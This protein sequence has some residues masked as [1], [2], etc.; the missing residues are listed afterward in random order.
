MSDKWYNPKEILGLETFHQICELFLTTTYSV[1]KS[2]GLS[3]PK[4]KDL[5][6]SVNDDD[7]TVGTPDKFYYVAIELEKSEDEEIYKTRISVMTQLHYNNKY[8]LAGWQS[9]DNL[10]L[11]FQQKDKIISSLKDCINKELEVFD[12]EMGEKSKG[13]ID[14]RWNLNLRT[15]ELDVH[16]DIEFKPVDISN[17][18]IFD[19]VS[20]VG[21]NIFYDIDLLD[22][23]E[24]APKGA[25][26]DLSVML[27]NKA[28][29]YAERKC[30]LVIKK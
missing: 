17:Y 14:G 28:I 20:G 9:A 24:Y 13:L 21:I 22:E 5:N 7:N 6:Q 2:K 19:A 11:L 27:K 8:A 26:E 4:L 18:M 23:E 1:L 30:K 15:V 16:N 10:L 25:D 3:F 12:E 29:Q